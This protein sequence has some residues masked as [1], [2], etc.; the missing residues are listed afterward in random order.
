MKFVIPGGTGH[1]GAALVRWLRPKGHEVVVLSR[2]HEPGCVWWDGR[3]LG[4]WSDEI[5]GADV[6]INLAGRTVNCRY[7]EEHFKEMMDS[8]VDSTQVVG[9]AIKQAAQPPRLWLQSSTATIYAHTFGE[10]NDE[11]DGEIGGNEKGVPAHWKRSIAIAEAWEE[12]LNVADTP[13]TRKVALRSAMTMSPDRGSVFETL[14]S[15][16]KKGLGGPI[17]G[18]RQY[19]SWIHADDFCRAV[20]FLTDREDLEGA[21]NICSPNPVTQRDF[22][23]ILREEAGVKVGLPASSWMI[24]IATRLMKTE[25]E[26][27]LKSRR[28]VP[29]RLTEAGFQFLFPKWEEAARDLIA[30]PIVG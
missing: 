19:V 1:V 25:S 8:R 9:Q 7:T 27:V 26:L 6:V 15:L 5:N 18:G 30:R 13:G 11:Y 12:T 20:E 21:V 14:L 29:R 22:S 28:V 16:T 10:P 2:R 24:E 23:R 17:A 3:S 4:A